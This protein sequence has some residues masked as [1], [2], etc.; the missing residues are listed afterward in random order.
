[1][2]DILTG[3]GRVGAAHGER[4]GEGS[5]GIQN[6]QRLFPQLHR[7]GGG[8]SSPLSG[9]PSSSA[10]ASLVVLLL[11]GVEGLVVGDVGDKG[12]EAETEAGEQVPEPDS[13]CIV[14]EGGIRG[15]RGES[16][17]PSPRM[18][19][20]GR[21][22]LPAFMLFTGLERGE[23][24]QTWTCSRRWGAIADGDK[25]GQYVCGRGNEETVRRTFRHASRLAHGSV[26]MLRSVW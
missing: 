5:Q 2:F 6:A 8:G 11:G 21:V 26:R 20:P 14:A 10:A 25:G 12:G 9:V 3:Q 16:Q 23:R 7:G 13:L 4:K 18:V 17:F 1:M 19:V 22:R 15:K 24:R